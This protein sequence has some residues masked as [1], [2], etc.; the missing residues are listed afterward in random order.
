V[1]C[2][3][4]KANN[5]E[6]VLVCSNC[7]YPLVSLM[8]TRKFNDASGDILKLPTTGDTRLLEKM[9]LRF[10]VG[11]GKWIDAEMGEQLTLGRVVEGQDGKPDVDLSPYCGADNE[12]GVSRFHCVIKRAGSS[13]VINDHGSTNGT[14]VNGDRL[15]NG[16][17]RFLHDGD[18]LFLGRLPL[19]VYFVR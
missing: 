3:R 11:E 8:S 18:A 16:D 13:L 9:K 12:F 17:P 2:N 15:I 6:G 1:Q 7:G 19:A 4:C 14:W 5:L 10:A